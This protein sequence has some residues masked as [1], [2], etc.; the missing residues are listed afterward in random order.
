[1][2]QNSDPATVVTLS[3]FEVSESRFLG[4]DGNL[5]YQSL[6]SFPSKAVSQMDVLEPGLAGTFVYNYFTPDENISYASDV[7]IQNSVTSLAD[8]KFYFIP[9]R[10]GE[11]ESPSLPRFVK[12]DVAP[13]ASAG[14]SLRLPAGKSLSDYLN[15][16]IFE[17]SFA[18][19]AASGVIFEETQANTILYN[20]LS[21]SAV[22]SGIDLSATSLTEGGKIL[23]NGINPISIEN[24]ESVL[25][26]VLANSGPEGYSYIDGKSAQVKKNTVL[27]NVAAVSFGASVSNVL[28]EDVLKSAQDPFSVY[29]EEILG[30]ISA[31]KSIQE[32]SIRSGSPNDIISDLYDVGITP[33]S[34]RILSAAEINTPRSSSI[35]GV[36]IEKQEI[37]PSGEIS[38]LSP[39]V[40]E[41]STTRSVIDPK[42]K[43]GCKYNY[44]ARVVYLVEI[45]SIAVDDAGTLQNQSCLAQ[46]L[47]AGRGSTY[48]VA[49][50]DLVPPMPPSDINF[51][52]DDTTGELIVSWDFP[53]NPTRDI[54]YFQIMRR[55]SIDAPF[56][57]IGMHF[58]NDA[59]SPVPFPEKIPN[60]LQIMQKIPINVFVDKGF[61][62]TK[63]YIYSVVSADAHGLMSAYSAQFEISY[64]GFRQKLVKNIVSRSGA[65]RV[66]PNFFLNR[67]TF[68]DS[69]KDSNSTRMRIFFDPEYFDVNDARG[70]SLQLLKFDLSSPSYKLQLINT[71]IQTGKLFNISLVNNYVSSEATSALSPAIR[72]LIL[73][74]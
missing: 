12:L 7:I 73:T 46:V 61:D 26:N 62:R 44:T 17:E 35:V 59:Y 49:C 25:I 3:D 64:D 10:S 14:S 20:H 18:S 58:F 69:M 71:D 50:E 5:T 41:G 21:A 32:S 65:P 56:E 6:S 8:Q 29:Y 54:K 63:K 36:I 66:Y 72:S 67:D 37:T 27:A 22:F 2:S 51:N 53:I 52:L 30:S 11:S 34:T 74:R 9:V 45:E 16:I 13:P 23:D 57:L 70:N 55:S 43:Y 48:T 39:I 60:R 31:A 28:M 42:I 4:S 1:M 40:L 33:I 19:S 38:K 24:R 15:N 47:V 68:I